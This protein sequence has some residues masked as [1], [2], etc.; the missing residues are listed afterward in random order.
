MRSRVRRLVGKNASTRP[1]TT[2]HAAIQSI[3]IARRWCGLGGRRGILRRL[4][5]GSNPARTRS[6]NSAGRSIRRNRGSWRVPR[7]RPP[8]PATPRRAPAGSRY[9]V[10]PRAA[11]RFSH[12]HRSCHGVEH[13]PPTRRPSVPVGRLCGD[14]RGGGPR[15]HGP[16][17]VM[18]WKL[19]P[20]R[21]P[22]STANFPMRLGPVVRHGQTA[23][24]SRVFAC[25]VTSEYRPPG[26]RPAMR[27][28]GTA[29]GRHR[30]RSVCGARSPVTSVDPTSRAHP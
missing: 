19:P 9:P 4:A 12:A 28:T 10:P 1:A 16:A 21:E 17:S 5:L 6:A 18:G 25:S 11:L 7:G 29:R 2:P 22:A 23:P 26:G 20:K 3:P 27:E 15:G 24:R 30:G 8:C 14:A 13:D